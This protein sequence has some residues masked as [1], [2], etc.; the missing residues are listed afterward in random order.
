MFTPLFHRVMIA[1]LAAAGLMAVAPAARADLNTPVFTPLMADVAFDS[2]LVTNA[3]PNDAVVAV[4]QVHVPGAAWIRL[5]LDGTLLD[6]D[7]SIGQG[8]YLRITS[9]LDGAV[10]TM[11]ATHLEQ[12]GRHSAYFNGDAVLVELIAPPASGSSKL[13]V[14]GAIY[15]LVPEQTADDGDA[16]PRTYCGAIDNRELSDDPRV[17]RIVFSNGSIGTTFIIDDP[18]H[19]FLTS[20]S[21]A[22]ALLTTSVIQFHAPLTFPNGTTLNHPSPE[23]QYVADLTSIQRISG[24]TGTGNNWGYFGALPNSTTNLT[25]FQAGGEYFELADVIPPVDGRPVRSY[26]NGFTQPPIFR[27]WSFVQK[28]EVGEYVG[29]SGTRIQFRV[30]LT[31]GDSGAAILDETT[32]KIIGIAVED[33]CTEFGGSNAGTAV[34]NPNLRMA[35]NHPLGVCVALVYNYPNG[36]PELLNPNGGT[37]VVVEVT[38]ANGASPEPGTGQFHYNANTGAGWQ[39]VSMNEIAANVYEAVFPAFPCGSF[40]D[41][42]FSAETTGGT[43]VPNQISNPINTFRATTAT[44]IN[45]LVDLDFETAVGWTVENVSLTAGAWERGIPAV[46][47]SN[48]PPP[49]A[50]ASDYDGSGQCWLTGNILGNEGD[51]DGGP[52][53]LRSP[54]YNLSGT[55][56]AFVSYARWFT[57]QPE[58]VDRLSVQVS[59]N[60]GLSYTTFEQ[61]AHNDGWKLSRHRVSDLIAVSPSMRFRF[62]VSD[63]PNNSRTEAALDAFSIIDY[64]CDATSCLR[65]DVNNDGVIDGRDV[66]DFVAVL[67]GSS[68]PGTQPFCAADMNGNGALDATDDVAAFVECLVNGT[69]P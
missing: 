62:V 33:G 8:A 60:G 27:T 30:D 14:A 13:V 31:N 45:V 48:V 54:A 17:A 22:A 36:L 2:G 20:G 18:N 12:W 9:L 25:P 58:D 44:A 52:T 34:N 37:T 53:R 69:C 64:Q 50:P 59:N 23:H 5:N 68:G 10:Q 19:T 11:H 43:R 55:T 24:A 39:T 28:T 1:T 42:Y 56:N 7:E 16:S 66:G 41:Y 49:G 35:L 51:V 6:G 26:G 67:L 65:G 46:N 3:G 63:N 40:V 29:F 38:G 15:D 4:E 32:G 21:V 61:I 47:A 57:N